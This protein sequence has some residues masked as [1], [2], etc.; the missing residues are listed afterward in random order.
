MGITAQVRGIA[1]TVFR[2][3][4]SKIRWICL[5]A[6]NLPAAALTIRTAVASD[7]EA[8]WYYIH[9]VAPICFIAGL[10][11]YYRLGRTERLR[12]RPEGLDALAI[13]LSSLRVLPFAGL[14]PYSGHTLFLSYAFFATVS[15]AFR[16]VVGAYLLW[17][18]FIK[19]GVYH[20]PISWG[21]GIIIGACLA[22]AYRR[23]VG[24]AKTGSDQEPTTGTERTDTPTDV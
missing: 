9:Y 19:L 22:V 11:V 10:F 6:A 23:V 7:W 21:V 15:L 17:V 3:W 24:T 5:I 1:E 20:D 4:R 14:L 2:R 18:T 8:T 13:A 16:S 12:L